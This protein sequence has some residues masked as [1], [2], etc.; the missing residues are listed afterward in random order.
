MSSK[1]GLEVPKTSIET[2]LNRPFP[3]CLKL[4]FQS[5]A[6]CEAIDMKLNVFLFLFQ[7]HANK[8]H[9]YKKILHLASFA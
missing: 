9:F 5:E 4:L 8:T 1:D 6:E 3:S 7:A 2:G